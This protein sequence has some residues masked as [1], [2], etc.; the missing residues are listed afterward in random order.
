M[1]DVREKNLDK[2]FVLSGAAAGFDTG[3]KDTA[4][5]DILQK[6]KA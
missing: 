4:L 2:N 1:T 5:P 3:G 6:S